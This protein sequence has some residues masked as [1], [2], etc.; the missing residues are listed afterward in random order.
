MLSVIIDSL[1]WELFEGQER[2]K[3]KL[4]PEVS[5]WDF[6]QLHVNS[7]ATVSSQTKCHRV[8]PKSPSCFW[9]ALMNQMSCLGNIGSDK[10]V[11]EKRV[12]QISRPPHTAVSDATCSTYDQV[13]TRDDSVAAS[14]KLGL[15]DM[16]EEKE[17]E[18]GRSWFAGVSR[19][20]VGCV[21]PGRSAVHMHNTIHRLT[22]M[23]C[24]LS[25]R[26]KLI[27]LRIFFS[28]SSFPLLWDVPGCTLVFSDSV[29]PSDN[30]KAIVVHHIVLPST[31]RHFLLI[32]NA[33]QS[34]HVFFCW[35]YLGKRKGPSM[36]LFMAWVCISWRKK[37][38]S[39]LCENRA[40]K[41]THQTL[42]TRECHL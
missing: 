3:K 41:K 6:C 26:C 8:L 37:N 24:M 14:I 12:A 9:M 17:E 20:P 21:H 32:Y 4:K 2:E 22:P 35:K 15:A 40:I 27:C 23:G 7:M 30:G 31:H 38:E 13:W 33:L 5:H 19:R 34:A 11:G 42:H 25:H 28:F 10:G 1:D 16:E 36:S 18:E 39:A 29:L